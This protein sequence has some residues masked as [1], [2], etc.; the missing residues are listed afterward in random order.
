MRKSGPLRNIKLCA[1]IAVGENSEDAGAPPAFS[2]VLAMVLDERVVESADPL[3][4]LAD[5]KCQMSNVAET[6]MQETRTASR[7]RIENY[8][9][10]SLQSILGRL[11]TDS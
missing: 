5:R 1:D 3:A 4:F 7:R 9:R 10:N 6:T 11:R 8:S 2:N